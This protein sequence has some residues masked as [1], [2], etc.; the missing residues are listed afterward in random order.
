MVY[1]VQY[2][3]GF[4]FQ[5]Y[6]FNKYANQSIYSLQ[7]IQAN[8]IRAVKFVRS[9]HFF[10]SI[11]KSKKSADRQMLS[12]LIAIMFLLAAA[13]YEKWINIKNGKNTWIVVWGENQRREFYCN[14]SKVRNLWGAI[15]STDAI[16]KRES[17]ERA[18]WILGASKCP[19]NAGVN[20]VCSAS[21]SCVSPRS[22]R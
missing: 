18:F 15:C 8:Q 20:P 16:S 11:K 14:S 3:I 5:W 7:I 2:I 22:L 21:S 1:F 6:F 4:C 19:I 13:W 17:R 10:I 9:H 12:I